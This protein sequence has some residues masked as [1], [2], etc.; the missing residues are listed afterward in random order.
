MT[1][2]G[3]HQNVHLWKEFMRMFLHENKCIQAY[4]YNFVKN[5]ILLWRRGRCL[6][7]RAWA[8]IKRMGAR[9]T[10]VDAAIVHTAC[11][12]LYH[13]GCSCS[14]VFSLLVISIGCLSGNENLSLLSLPL[15]SDYILQLVSSFPACTPTY[16]PYPTLPAKILS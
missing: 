9:S 13:N 8:P 16:P 3:P 7:K 14:V 15:P 12:V 1:C 6:R 2:Q 11:L 10:S 4:E 5:A